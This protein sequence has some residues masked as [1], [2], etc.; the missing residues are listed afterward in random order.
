MRNACLAG[1]DG[2]QLHRLDL[3]LALILWFDQQTFSPRP[4]YRSTPIRRSRTV[5]CLA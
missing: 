5:P 3:T 2:R 4:P 1:S